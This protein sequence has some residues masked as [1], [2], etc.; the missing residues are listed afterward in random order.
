M[1]YQVDDTT[2]DGRESFETAVVVMVN[3]KG[4]DERDAR[5]RATSVVAAA[6]ATFNENEDYSD[7]LTLD[8]SKG[9]IEETRMV[10]RGHRIIARV[11]Q[12]TSLANAFQQGFVS[13]LATGRATKYPMM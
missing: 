5:D 11:T 9:G 10:G 3:V 2:E 1:S 12:V 13:F 7:G 6:L 4:V 8:S